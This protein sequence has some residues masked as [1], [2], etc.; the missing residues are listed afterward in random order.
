MSQHS[1]T[2][3]TLSIIDIKEDIVVLTNKRYRTV[4]QVKAINFDLLSEDEQ[5][6]IIYAYASLINS[7]N[8]PIQILVKTRQ[9]NITS[10]LDYLERAKQAQPSQVLKNQIS[11]YQQFVN[12]L[13]V[14]NNVLFKT[15]YVVIPF[16]G[17]Q[18]DKSS[19]FDP[20]LNILG[21]SK[22]TVTTTY[23][24]K[25]FAQAREKLVQMTSDLMGQFQRI[26]LQVRQLTS[27]EL[28]GLYYTLYNPEE[29][30][31]EQRVGQDINEYTTPMVHPSMR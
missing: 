31:S 11:S 22:S 5:D 10:Y 8:Y 12:K 28:V 7:I 13:V 26:G 15:F 30:S 29:D 6:S 4:L 16:D 20:L 17:I 14:E 23:T 1:S 2:Q 19:I 3:S 9:L 18:V 27:Q 25:E 24:E 21:G